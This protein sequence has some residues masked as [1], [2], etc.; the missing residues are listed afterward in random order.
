MINPKNTTINMK[1]DQQEK[2]QDGH[3][4]LNK[5]S[6]STRLLSKLKCSDR[7]DRCGK[8]EEGPPPRAWRTTNE[9]T[10]KGALVPM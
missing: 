10:R 6:I 3:I 4:N 7:S 2:G 1:N 5:S 9:D 8:R